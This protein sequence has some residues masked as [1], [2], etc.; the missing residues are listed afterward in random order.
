MYISIGVFF[1]R[2][3]I[4]P[5]IKFE[6]LIYTTAVSYYKNTTKYVSVWTKPLKY[7]NFDLIAIC[8]IGKSLRRYEATRPAYFWFYFNLIKNVEGHRNYNL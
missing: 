1:Y 4:P 2:K 7:M 5:K 8:S 6:S 3:T